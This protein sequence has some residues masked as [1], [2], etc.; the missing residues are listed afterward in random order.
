LIKA[1]TISISALANGRYWGPSMTQSSGP[2][3]K[4]H[5]AWFQDIH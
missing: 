5:L 1:S 3:S 2:D 4:Q